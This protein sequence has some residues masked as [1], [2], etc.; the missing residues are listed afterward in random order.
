MH[1]NIPH[2][3][4]IY[5]S[6]KYLKFIGRW[7]TTKTWSLMVRWWTIAHLQSRWNVPHSQHQPLG[8]ASSFSVVD[9]LKIKMCLQYK[10]LW[11]CEHHLPWRTLFRD[12]KKKFSKRGKK[13]TR[14]PCYDKKWNIPRLTSNY[15]FEEGYGC[16]LYVCTKWSFISHLWSVAVTNIPRSH[17]SL[18]TVETWNFAFTTAKRYTK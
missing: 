2:L 18:C 11:W 15:L 4:S 16:L 8:S 1:Q 14:N 7:P 9:I 6:S 3:T 17:V 12:I 5:R 10:V 13:D